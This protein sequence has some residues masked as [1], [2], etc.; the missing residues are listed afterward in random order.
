MNDQITPE[1]IAA[2]TPIIVDIGGWLKAGWQ[3]FVADVMKYVLASLIF[4]LVGAISCGILAGPMTVGFFK[5]LLKKARGQNFEYGELFDGIKTQFVPA[6]L[7]L[8]ALIIPAIILGAVPFVGKT[9]GTVWQLFAGMIATYVFFII[10]ESAVP[11]QAG[12]LQQLAKD[13]WARVQPAWVMILV[14][15][16][17]VALINIAGMLLCC[18]G[19]FFTM[20]IVYMALTISY[21]AIFRNEKPVLPAA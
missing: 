19:L 17:V 11:V 21:L 4:V 14:L 20:P 18:V 3:F 10:A 1:P 9:L 5:C 15:I 16:V 13:V 8:L 2:T 7:V 12:A 6:L